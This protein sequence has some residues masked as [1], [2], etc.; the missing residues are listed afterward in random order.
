MPFKII[1]S[2]IS[3]ISESTYIRYKDKNKELFKKC[4]E[5]MFEKLCGSGIR[6]QRD[7]TVVYR[8]SKI[9]SQTGADDEPRNYMTLWWHRWKF[10]FKGCFEYKSSYFWESNKIIYLPGYLCW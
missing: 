3:D 8:S 9:C 1:W 4:T 2:F 7:E 5:Y 6:V 10:Y